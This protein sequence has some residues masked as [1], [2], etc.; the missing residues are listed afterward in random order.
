MQKLINEKNFI[1]SQIFL[2]FASLSVADFSTIER[3]TPQIEVISSDCDKDGCYRSPEWIN[4][5]QKL[6]KFIERANYSIHY[7]PFVLAAAS[8]DA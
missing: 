1:Y 6:D 8:T 4:L 7:R 3:K 5:N 2:S